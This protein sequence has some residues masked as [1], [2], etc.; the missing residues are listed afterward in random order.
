[1]KNVLV[2]LSQEEVYTN[3]RLKINPRNGEIMECLVASR[4]IFK[5]TDSV[6]LRKTPGKGS[7][8][9]LTGQ[10]VWEVEEASSASYERW[11]AAQKANRR[12]AANRAKR[13][14]F[15]LAA[16]NDF[17]LFITLTLSPDKIDR[18]DYKAAVK[19]L[20]QWL[21]NRVRRNGLFYVLVPE[22]HKDG[23]IHFHGLIN[24]AAVKL[25]DSHHRDRKNGKVIYNVADWTV[26]FTT[27]EKLTGDYAAVCH[28]ISKY[29]TKQVAHEGTIGGR[30]YLHGGKLSSPVYKPFSADYEAVDGK[31]V[32]IEEAALTL[33]Y[34]K[35]ADLNGLLADDSRDKG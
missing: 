25:V 5:T 31:V 29:V 12:R 3:G 9:P 10:D 17:D 21:D 8:R 23:A 4:P 28:Y 24:S 7:K 30:Y 16:C 34:V 11:E 19:K 1:M 26:G 35:E 2:P 33:K 20:S 27:A 6:E 13:Q 14:V 15:D 18:Y 22:Y 32:E